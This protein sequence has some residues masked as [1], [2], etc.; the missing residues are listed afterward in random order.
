VK[1]TW[2]LLFAAALLPVGGAAQAGGYL[3]GAMKSPAS[4]DEALGRGP[5]ELVSA[6]E[7]DLAEPPAPPSHG[8][9][10]ASAPKP[11]AASSSISGSCCSDG[12]ASDSGCGDLCNDC[13]GPTWTARVGAVILERARPRRQR[14][15]ED[16]TGGT[17]GDGFSDA[18]DFGF[19][20]GPDI[21]LTRWLANGNGIEVRYFG[22]LQWDAQAHWMSATG[23]ALPTNPPRVGAGAAV[24]DANYIS[25]LNSTEVNYR[26]A[27]NQT[28][29][30]LAGFRWIELHED[31]DVD[32]DFG[33]NM[34]EVG[35]NTDNHLYGAQTGAEINLLDRGGPF[36]ALA[37]F[38]GGIYGNDA[39]ND[40]SLNQSIGPDVSFT[41]QTGRV[42]FVGDIAFTGS[43]QLTDSISLR[44]G[45]QLLFIDGVALASEQIFA[46]NVVTG[47]GVDATG[48][49]F[50]HGAITSIDFV[51]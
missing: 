6:F 2:R 51:W 19:E 23:W 50:Y 46:T 49:A 40:F 10:A 36:T 20:A 7:P 38:K 16:R 26:E 32:A 17:A 5:I 42:A 44:T 34:T 28:V 12:C 39:D 31:L 41:D 48:F 3:D 18:F 25:R 11:V 29:S 21:T 37:W 4:F 43:Y 13:C 30:L 1:T 27:P 24:I 47:S 8:G 9:P 14:V 35:W 15:I 22:A 33:S 45:Y